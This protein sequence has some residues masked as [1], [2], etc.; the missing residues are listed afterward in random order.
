MKKVNKSLTQVKD[1]ETW[2]V[3]LSENVW[4]FYKAVFGIQTTIK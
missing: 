2:A 3:T 1:Q 4:G